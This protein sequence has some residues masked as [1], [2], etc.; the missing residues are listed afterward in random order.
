ME[1]EPEINPEGD[2]ESSPEQAPAKAKRL[3]RRRTI[4][5]AIGGVTFVI[6]LALLS[7]GIFSYTSDDGDGRAPA[8]AVLDLGESPLP[9]PSRT[10]RPTA[11]ATPTPIPAPPLG[12]QPYQLI[13][14]KLG[15]NAPVE[16][17]GLD[18]N[19]V[20][21]VPTG[22]NAADVV[23]WYNFSAKPGTGSNAVFAGHVTWFGP[24]V[25]YNLRSM[26]AGDSIRLIGQDG[27]ELVYVVNSVF[28]LDATD[29]DS[30]QVMWGT[31]TDT[32][33]IITC[34]GAYTD[35]NDPVF[36]GEY[37]HRLVVRA[38]LQN[39][40]NAGAPQAPASGG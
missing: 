16:T 23:A 4:A 19:A 18:P 2:F 15:V 27:T 20:P 9:T 31:E 29:P 30:I 6:G 3:T 21:E 7:F 14:D 17:Y 37:S 13:I 33:T 11:V 34:D 25:F 5:L 32:M 1:N 28:Q 35:T 36:G 26:A 10:P 39:V 8:P 22:D 12:D 24:A 40:S 38:D